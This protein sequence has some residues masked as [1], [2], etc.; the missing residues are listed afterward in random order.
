MLDAGFSERFEAYLAWIGPHHKVLGSTG[1]GRI[2]AANPRA[3]CVG[4][5]AAVLLYH[6]TIVDGV[7][8]GAEIFARETVAPLP[9]APTSL[10]RPHPLPLPTP[11]RDPLLSA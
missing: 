10:P 3:G 5:P 11:P 6:P 8:P 7:R 2:T 4:D 9:A 1:V